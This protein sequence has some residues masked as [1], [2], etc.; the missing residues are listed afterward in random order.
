M[1]NYKQNEDFVKKK[2]LPVPYRNGKYLHHKLIEVVIR[3]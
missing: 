2:N 1:E 3:F